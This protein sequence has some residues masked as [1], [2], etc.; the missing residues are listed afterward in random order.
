M[1]DFPHVLS[2]VVKKRKAT[3]QV[4][5]QVRNHLCLTEALTEY[6]H[7]KLIWDHFYHMT[8]ILLKDPLPVGALEDQAEF[9]WGYTEADKKKYLE[10]AEIF[11]QL[12]CARYTAKSLTPYMMKLIDHVPELMR[13][14][15]SP[16]ARF[17]SEG[18]EHLNYQHNCFY[19]QHTTRNGGTGNPDPLV[20]ILQSTW[21]RLYHSIEQLTLSDDEEKREIGHSFISFCTCHTAAAVIQRCFRAYIVRKKLDKVGWTSRPMSGQQRKNNLKVQTFIRDIFPR[22]GGRTRPFIG[23]NFVLV[24]A[25]PAQKKKKMTQIELKK[26]LSIMGVE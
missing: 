16:I 14:L 25:V 1:P 13:T 9:Q 12:F 20:A 23:M 11:Y 18:G 21:N 7:V 8:E 22:K 15:S 2:G 19:F 5:P 24:G 17:Q 3:L 10:H 4:Q 6:E 26:K